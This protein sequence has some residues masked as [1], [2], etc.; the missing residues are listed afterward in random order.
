MGAFKLITGMQVVERIPTKGMFRI[1]TFCETNGW[2]E[3]FCPPEQLDETK[4]R[5]IDKVKSKDYT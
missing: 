4:K 1:S 3:V 5:E 2:I